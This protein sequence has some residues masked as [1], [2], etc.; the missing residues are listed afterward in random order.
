MNANLYVSGADLYVRFAGR[1]DE[2]GLT[3]GEAGGSLH[4]DDVMGETLPA[5]LFSR[6]NISHATEN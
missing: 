6:P 4:T 1:G 3:R 5:N 2:I